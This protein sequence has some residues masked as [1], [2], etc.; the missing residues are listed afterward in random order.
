M[1][2]ARKYVA[3][4]TSVPEDAMVGG[5]APWLLYSDS[6][7][8]GDYKGGF[9]YDSSI[10]ERHDS[11]RPQNSAVDMKTKVGQWLWPYTLD[12]GDQQIVSRRGPV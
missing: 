2:G 7:F 8:E 4:A 12:F 6:M 10:V 11:L 5:R 3:A 9:L 1:F